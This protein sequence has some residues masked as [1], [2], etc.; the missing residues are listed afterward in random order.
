MLPVGSTFSIAKTDV[1]E[2][3]Q[4]TAQERLVK[5]MGEEAIKKLAGKKITDKQREAHMR[6]LLD[7]YFDITAIGRFALGRN[8]RKADKKQQKEYLKLFK[9][10]VVSTYASRFREYSGEKFEVIGS[11]TLSK[12][13]VMVNSKIIPKEGPELAIDWR[14]RKKSSKK[15]KVIDIIIEGVSMGVTQRSEFASIIQHGGGKIDSLLDELRN[16]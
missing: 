8:W 3:K 13:D 2:K 12:R 16:K 1:K 14:V 5:N 9:D 11:K 7:R 6:A 15:Y 10:M 4:M